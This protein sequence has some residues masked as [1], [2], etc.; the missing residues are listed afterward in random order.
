M[1]YLHLFDIVADYLRS[2]RAELRFERGPRITSSVLKRARAKSPI[3]IPDSMA[4]FYT[5]VG[6]GVIFAW[7][8]TGKGKHLPSGGLEIPKIQDHVLTTIDQVTW[9]TEWDDTE[10]YC[11]TKNPA[12]AKKTALK[13]RKWMPIFSEGNGD[14]FCLD[15]SLDPAPVVWDQ[16]DWFDGG[17]GKNGHRFATSLKKFFSSW[18]QVCFQ[19]P[20]NSYWPNVLTRTSVNWNSSHFD[21]N[22][23]LPSKPIPHRKTTHITNATV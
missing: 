2:R 13:M 23:R 3:H 21:P 20:R 10:D 7:S 22:Y 6:N 15:T 5:E 12:L 17:T 11:L 8:A 14:R 4:E 16:H 1:Q 19:P 9:R 18:A